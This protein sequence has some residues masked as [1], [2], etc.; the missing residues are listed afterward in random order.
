MTNIKSVPKRIYGL[1]LETR[2]T[3]FLSVQSAFSLE[4]AIFYAKLEYEKTNPSKKGGTLLEARVSLFAT[5]TIEEMEQFKD[6]IG[7]ESVSSPILEDRPSIDKTSD[8]IGDLFDAF[9]KMTPKHLKAIPTI[10]EVPE[11]I[12]PVEIKNRLM[13]SIIKNK[14]MKLL[15]ENKSEFTESELKYLKKRMK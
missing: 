12:T 13:A 7:D 14:D 10:D 15:N 3:A 1:V 8:A 11:P 6:T 4:E 9:D 2:G 5:K